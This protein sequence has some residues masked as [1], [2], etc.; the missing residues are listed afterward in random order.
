MPSCCACMRNVYTTVSVIVLL[1]LLQRRRLACVPE[2]SL[3]GHTASQMKRALPRAHLDR[4]AAG[5][6]AHDR[7]PLRLHE[8]GGGGVWYNDRLH[9]E[10]GVGCCGPCGLVA[11]QGACRGFFDAAAGRVTVV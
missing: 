11:Q 10:G 5:T 8:R 2:V 4:E 9:D 1:H 6:V 3:Q 7:R